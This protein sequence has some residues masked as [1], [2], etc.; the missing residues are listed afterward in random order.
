M[1]GARSESS[2]GATSGRADGSLRIC[3]VSPTYFA[4]ESVLGGGERYAEELSRA[5]AERADV[6]LISFGREPS[7]EQHGPRGERVILRSWSSSLLA[8][9]SPRLFREL[10][11]ADVVHCFQ[12]HVLPTFL[13]LWIAHR[14]GAR[15]FVTD[16]GGGGWT[17][18]YQI[19]QSRWLTAHLPLSEY[20]A[21]SFP[22]RPRPARVIL[23]GVDLDTFRMRTAPTHD[24][25]AVFLG[26]I[27]PHKGIHHLVTGLPAGVPLHVIG[28]TVDTQY[29]AHLHQLAA[30]KSV[31]FLHGLDDAEVVAQLQRAMVLV[32]P[33]PV[34]EQGNAGVAELLGLAPLEAMA[35]GA[36]VIASRTA[37]LPEVAGQDGVAGLLVAP[38]DP[39]AIGEAIVKMRAEEAVWRIRSLAARARVEGNFTWSATAA[40]CVTAYECAR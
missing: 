7:R 33:T 10:A 39:A 40:R 6:R 36:P 4:A 23:G 20:A 16:L 18:G 1:M 8:P 31:H 17:P 11:G 34:D 2:R 22:G 35:C 25:S 26:R 29:L 38:N 24:G 5:M 37:S 14:R 21:R 30:G 9:F 27:L 13:A 15:T 3:F 19:D 12:Y 32:H 28:S